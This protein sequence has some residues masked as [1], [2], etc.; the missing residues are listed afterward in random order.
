[1]NQHE[2]FTEQRNAIKQSTEASAYQG[3]MRTMKR[4]QRTDKSWKLVPDMDDVLRKFTFEK[5]LDDKRKIVLKLWHRQAKRRNYDSYYDPNRYFDV[6]R[7]VFLV[8]QGKEVV[9]QFETGIKPEGRGLLPKVKQAEETIRS[10][11]KQQE[12]REKEQRAKQEKQLATIKAA[13]GPYY[14]ASP[15]DP[16]NVNLTVAPDGKLVPTEHSWRAGIRVQVDDN[17]LVELQMGI[18]M[19]GQK[20]QALF[21]L[22]EEAA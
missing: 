22:I 21:R 16:L 7:M 9:R 3:L 10:M 1:M 14:K 6:Y 8:V 17:G 12:D 4:V 11:F 18:K 5:P 13:L 20:A 19:T 15:S 2:Q